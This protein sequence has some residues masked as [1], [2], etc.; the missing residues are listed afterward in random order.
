[1][2]PIVFIYK[3]VRFKRLPTDFPS[4]PPT[5]RPAYVSLGPYPHFPTSPF[6]R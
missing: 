3:Q 5:F 1:M 4:L 2:L 6:G